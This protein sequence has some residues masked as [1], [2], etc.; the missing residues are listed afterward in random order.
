MNRGAAFVLLALAGMAGWW[1]VLGPDV[2]WVLPMA[3]GG[4]LVTARAVRPRHTARP[5]TCRA[6][7]C[8]R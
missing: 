6:R 4:G 5:R 1:S 2:L 3:V 7:Q 8:R